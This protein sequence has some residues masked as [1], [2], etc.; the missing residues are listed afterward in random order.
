MSI[1]HIKAIITTVILVGVAALGYFG[2]SYVKNLGF[3]EANAAC[4]KRFGEYTKQIDD[5]LTEVQTSVSQNAE[6][7]IT[8][9]QLL[10]EDLRRIGFRVSKLPTT[11]VV[12]GKCVPNPAALAEVKEAV[13]RVNAEMS[14]K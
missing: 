3:Q 4:E 6:T 12:D 5:K 10:Q 1:D 9:N 2:F 8:S 13:R 11:I 14:K 7:M